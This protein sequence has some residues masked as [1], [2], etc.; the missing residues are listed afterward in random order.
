MFIFKSQ[1]RKIQKNLFWLY[2]SVPG[3]G[4]S[5][6][7]YLGREQVGINYENGTIIITIMEY[8]KE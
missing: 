7:K 5:H 4:H 6:R 3:A 2:F 8:D 1:F